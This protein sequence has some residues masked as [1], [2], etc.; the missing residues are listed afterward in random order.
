MYSKKGSMQN[1][2]KPKIESVTGL[3]ST[4]PLQF[5]VYANFMHN[6]VWLQIICIEKKVM[7][8]IHLK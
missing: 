3:R 2:S 4:Q 1:S 6:P 5:Y 7:C 8:E